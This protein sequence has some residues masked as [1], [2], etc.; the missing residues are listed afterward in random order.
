MINVKLKENIYK[1]M[2]VITKC[3]KSLQHISEMQKCLMLF[4]SYAKLNFKIAILDL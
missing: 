1:N 3:K 4:L 2:L